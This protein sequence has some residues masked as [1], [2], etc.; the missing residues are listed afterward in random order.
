MLFMLFVIMTWQIDHL[1][2]V[3]A[4][5][6]CFIILIGSFT[7]TPVQVGCCFLLEP[8]GGA[9]DSTACRPQPSQWRTGGGGAGRDVL[10]STIASVDIPSLEE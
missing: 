7:R 8:C 1:S 2:N 6:L 10:D 4:E 3:L 5:M 9:V